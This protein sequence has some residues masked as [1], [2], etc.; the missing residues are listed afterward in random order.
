MAAASDFTENNI[1]N[2]LLRGVAFQ[3]A[4]AT[5]IALH[6]ADPGETGANEI[7]TANWPAYARQDAAQGGTIASGWT[8]PSNGTSLNAKQ[9]L[10]PVHDG[11]SEITATHYSIWDAQTGGNML[12]GA[13]L[14]TART[15][16]PGDVFVVNEQK[17]TAQVL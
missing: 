14:D 13:A 9:V 12:L 7:S 16:A 4:S 8:A 17:L 11:A 2:A 5:Y 10:F 1:I 3:Q 15:L 6:T